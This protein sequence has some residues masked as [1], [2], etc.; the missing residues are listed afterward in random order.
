MATDLLARETRRAK[1]RA[2]LPPGAAP[3]PG[4][5]ADFVETCTLFVR[6]AGNGE[7]ATAE[8]GAWG[9]NE[10]TRGDLDV[11]DEPRPP[12]LGVGTDTTAPPSLAHL[13]LDCRDG[14]HEI[15]HPATLARDARL[16]A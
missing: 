16:F 13:L 9:M 10:W 11:Y 8:A 12:A 4:A 2:P 14:K 1:P 15:A 6:D 7:S 3:P 5:D